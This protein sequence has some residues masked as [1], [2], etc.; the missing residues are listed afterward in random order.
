M[1]KER[2]GL[3]K[4][5]FYAGI[6]AIEFSREQLRSARKEVSK[7]LDDFVERG[8]RLA[9]HEDS[10][11][12]AFMVALRPKKRVPTSDE[13]EVIVPDYDDMTVTQ[14]IDQLKRLSTKELDIV[15]E[16]ERHNLN[17]VRVVR[18][19]ERELDEA[20]I[21]PGFDELPVGAIINRLDDLSEQ[22]LAAIKEYEKT[23]RNRV[24]V[25]KAIDRRLAEA[26]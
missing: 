14:I 18:Q 10:I 19:I 5:M 12:K 26:A 16:Y 21:I 2:S 6:G 9:E 13:V 4:Q 24:T 7:A 23:H 15:S 20:R 11:V 1:E 3:I 25:L 8:E 22:E 17:R